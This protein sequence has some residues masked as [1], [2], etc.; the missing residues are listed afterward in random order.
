MALAALIQATKAKNQSLET[1]QAVNSRMSE[2]LEL[3]RKEPSLR[4]PIS[5][6]SRDI[7]AQVLFG[8]REEDAKT[9]SDIVL[10]RM[11]LGISAGRGDQQAEKIADLAGKEL[12]WSDEEK[13]QRV[14]EFRA[15]LDKDRSCLKSLLS[16]TA[17]D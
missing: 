3:A 14:A 12:G 1:H 5:P 15:E 6:D 11:H 17:R 16:K 10:R 2:L 4:A 13:K 8:L 7:Y 9:L